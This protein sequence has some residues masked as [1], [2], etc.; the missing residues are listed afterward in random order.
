[1]W[2]ESLDQILRIVGHSL[3][4]RSILEKKKTKQFSFLYEYVHIPCHLLIRRLNGNGFIANETRIQ[5]TGTTS[6]STCRP[7]YRFRCTCGNSVLSTKVL[8]NA[9]PERSLLQFLVGLLYSRCEICVF[10]FYLHLSFRS[11]S[12][13][14]LDNAARHDFPDHKSFIQSINI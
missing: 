4:L 13:S 2:S 12:S 3:A 6:V 9:V 11:R 8:G 10:I 14:L 7:A 1:M 5:K